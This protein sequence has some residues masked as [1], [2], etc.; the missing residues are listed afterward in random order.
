MAW[1]TSTHCALPKP[2]RC[3]RSSRLFHEPVPIELVPVL[4]LTAKRRQ[5]PGLS[6]RRLHAATVVEEQQRYVLELGHIVPSTEST[7][8][9]VCQTSFFR[10]VLDSDSFRSPRQT[11]PMTSSRPSTS[12]RLSLLK[13]ERPNLPVL[14]AGTGRSLKTN[15]L[16][17]A[18][19]FRTISYDGSEALG[20][21][22]TT[23]PPTEFHQGS[24]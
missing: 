19:A 18:S 20:L 3:V 14:Q 5:E 1:S 13:L 24:K 22:R 2:G 21:R 11:P 8:L 10:L 12:F 16:N 6:D 17:L 7:R 4:S 23:L 9:C 15:S